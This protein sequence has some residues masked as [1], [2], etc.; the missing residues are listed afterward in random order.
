M[1]TTLIITAKTEQELRNL[2]QSELTNLIQYFHIN[3]LVPNATKTIYT[4]FYPKRQHLP[5]YPYISSPLANKILSYLTPKQSTLP[6]SPE[7][8]TAVKTQRNFV[9]ACHSSKQPKHTIFRAKLLRKCSR[10]PLLG[11]IIQDDLKHNHTISKT[12]GKLQTFAHSLKYANKLLPR[13]TLRDLY[14]THAYPHLIGNITV[15]GTAKSSKMYI[16]PLAT[17]QKKLVRLIC[18]VPPRTHTAP[19]MQQL[20]TLNIYNLYTY[21]TAI[22]VHK[23]RYPKTELNRPQHN[24]TYTTITQVHSHNTR[25]SQSGSHYIPIQAEARRAAH[26]TTYTTTRNSTVWNSLPPGI[27]EERN[28]KTFKTWLHSHLLAQQ[29]PS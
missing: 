22:E 24:H 8:R 11:M 15:W 29:A 12:I 28:L 18:N 16:K 3:N 19:L 21:R 20:K 14:Y 23:F 10:G 27:R 7:Y 2:A 5:P 13:R 25:H 1:Q 9:L 26:R 4:S 17:L 6:N